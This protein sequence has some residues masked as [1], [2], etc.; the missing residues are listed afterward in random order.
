MPER[1]GRVVRPLLGMTRAET[2]AYC[3]AHGL[4]WRED[5]SN[6]TSARGVLRAAL[7]L[8]PAAEHNVL[9]TLATLRDE[10]AVLDDV[11]EA[12]LREGVRR[13]RRGRRRWPAHLRRGRGGEVPR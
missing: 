11:V 6:A 12:V 4:P 9:A 13:L 2:A 5:T 3:R 10:A 1:S 7:A 8:H